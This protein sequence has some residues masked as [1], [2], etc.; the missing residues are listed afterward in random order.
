VI[1]YFFV[2]RIM[3]QLLHGENEIESKLCQRLTVQAHRKKI[4]KNSGGGQFLFSP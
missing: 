1:L 4:E 3:K 2:A